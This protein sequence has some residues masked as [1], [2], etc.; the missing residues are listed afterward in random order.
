ML[1]TDGANNGGA[2]PIT[3]ATSVIFFL[4]FSPVLFS[5][6]LTFHPQMKNN[7][8]VITAVGVGD[9]IDMK[10]L[11]A[12]VSA[13]ASQY[14]FTSSG[15]DQLKS[16]VSALVKTTCGP[17]RRF[18]SRWSKRKSSWSG[19]VFRKRKRCVTMST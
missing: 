10:Q 19:V 11:S 6:L 12:I 16:V 3:A 8:T 4:I 7:G 5:T 18:A 17:A 15:F 2:D 13:P 1:I 9:G 14:L